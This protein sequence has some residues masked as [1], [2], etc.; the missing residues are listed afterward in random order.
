MKTRPEPYPEPPPHLTERSKNLWRTIGP[1]EAR[2][3]A[4][5]TLFLAALEALDRAE[6]ARLV[7][8]GEGMTTTTERS[9][10]A[11]VHPLLK[12]ERDAR[13]QFSKLWTDLRLHWPTNN[14]LMD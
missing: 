5:Q 14:N 11:H 4:R 9:G 8:E 10:V 13:A 12:V 3:I 6:Q 1:R 2:G 7:I